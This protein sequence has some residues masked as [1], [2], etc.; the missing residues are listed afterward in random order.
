M[1]YPDLKAFGLAFLLA[2]SAFGPQA[3]A[4]D[5]APAMSDIIEAWLASPHGDRAS[6]AFTHWNED[7][8]I[9]GTC[10]VCH[11]STG[12]VDY[13]AGPMTTPGTIDHP[14]DLG[15]TIDCVA[16]HNKS[17]SSLAAVPF[18]SGVVVEAFGSSAI[19]TVCHQGRASSQT[20]ETRTA[21]MDDDTVV[22]DLGFIN[23]HYKPAASTM[24]GGIARGGF[25]YPG[26]TYKGRFAHVPDLNTCTQCHNPHS[27]EVSID[28][29][30][31]CHKD[32]KAFADI[33]ISSADFDGN[34]NT[35]EGIA[36][37]ILAMHARLGE[38]I[39]LYA[40]E[41]AG[42]SI[43]YS[44][45]SYPYFFTD[46]D[47]D[48]TASPGESIFPNRYQSWT[49]R[50]VKAAYNYQLVAKETA[51]YTHNPHYALQLLYDSLENLSERVEVEMNGLV[52]P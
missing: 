36:A 35:T 7:G 42:A 38:A 15:T 6:E 52:R 19:C 21:N 12:L 17:A 3:M 50:L 23:I 37:P 30:K 39:Q 46:T 18:P 14:V 44:T 32:A 2:A 25:E 10:A 41:V 5:Q 4:Q 40:S 24:M 31:T 16:C 43:A 9:P 20:V 8:E 45:E 1:H 49:P 29:C 11:S 47:A 26:K 48:G 51:I 33:R 13:V 22:G 28:T 34:G 27:L